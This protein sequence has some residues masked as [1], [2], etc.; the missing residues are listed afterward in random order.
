MDA[1]FYDD[2]LGEIVRSGNVEGHAVRVLGFYDAIHA[3]S[4]YR[5]T[6]GRNLLVAMAARTGNCSDLN[7]A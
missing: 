6:F 5:G 2:R 4:R 1:G 3:S 7:L